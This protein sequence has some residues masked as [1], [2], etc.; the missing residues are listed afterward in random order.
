M[1]SLSLNIFKS[2][3]DVF[4]KVLLFPNTRPVL[5]KQGFSTQ[6]N[7]MSYKW[8]KLGNPVFPVAYFLLTSYSFKYVFNKMKIKRL[9]SSYRNH[10]IFSLLWVSSWTRWTYL[11]QDI[12]SFWK[13]V[14]AL[15]FRRC[16]RIKLSFYFF[17]P[18]PKSELF[19]DI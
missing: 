9:R 19:V 2:G 8:V 4:L 18:K 5:V 3:Q 11:V 12:G 7:F 16:N 13:Y 17:K 1:N 10:S 14:C 6:W 15:Y